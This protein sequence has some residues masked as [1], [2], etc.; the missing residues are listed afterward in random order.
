MVE[1]TLWSGPCLVDV[2]PSGDQT[3]GS[4]TAVKGRETCVP[5][6]LVPVMMN[7]IIT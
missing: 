6:L 1:R 5:V 3:S 4:E 2:A 7:S